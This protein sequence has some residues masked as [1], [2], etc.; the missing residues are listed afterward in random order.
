MK[1]P[2][3]LIAILTLVV[4]QASGDDSTV[5]GFRNDG[6]GHYRGK[7][8]DKFDLATG[9]NNRGKTGFVIGASPCIAGDALLIRTSREL[10]C[11]GQ[12]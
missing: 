12:K 3:G 9:A 7:V 11:V 2:T 10:I 1:K 8:V 5:V 4:A 6:T